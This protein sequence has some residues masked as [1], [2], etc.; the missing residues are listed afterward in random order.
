VIEINGRLAENS[1]ETQA[2]GNGYTTRNE[3]QSADSLPRNRIGKTGLRRLAPFVLA[4]CAVLAVFAIVFYALFGHG[5]VR[6]IYDGKLSGV[7][8]WVM[9][10]RSTTPLEDYYAVA[11]ALLANLLLGL[12]ILVPAAVICLSK[13]LGVLLAAF[14]V[15]VSSFLLFCVFEAIPSLV[16]PLRLDA[17][18]TYYAYKQYYIPDDQLGWR[19]KPLARL[20]RSDFNESDNS[21]TAGTGEPPARL[22]WTNDENGFRNGSLQATYDVVV[23]GDSFMAFGQSEHDTFPKRLQKYLG[24]TVLNLGIGGYGPFQ[25]LEVL[26]QYG[27]PKQP[28]YAL[29]AFYSGNDL[30][31]IVAY[32]KW[33]EG[34]RQ[35][36]YNSG[37]LSVLEGYKV[38]L[39]DVVAKAG[40]S[41][42]H[43][44]DWLLERTGA[45]SGYS[46][47][48]G[49]VAVLDLGGNRHFAMSFVDYLDT[50]P[51]ET[52][53]RSEEW[54][55]LRTILSEFKAVCRRN[56]I[57]PVVLYIP[58]ATE[59]YAK[60]ST[61]ESG[62]GWRHLRLKQ[63]A[64]AG[65]LQT[66]F[67]RLAGE[68]KLDL[69]D[70]TP[71]FQEAAE[72]GQ[73][74]YYS[75]DSHWNA[76]GRELAARFVAEQLKTEGQIHPVGGPKIRPDAAAPD[77]GVSAAAP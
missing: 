72:R 61:N 26:K 35:P 12:I 15:L 59:V 24:S 31:D 22:E 51:P 32:V 70:I 7:A 46:Y 41:I 21:G 29:F 17:L 23:T 74:V 60:Y 19:G 77:S 67:A 56:G 44:I 20:G 68:L 36:M 27:V 2:G 37:E 28:R 16:A 63:I 66:A 45:T 57:K 38:V 42:A 5:I 6:A 10:G 40:R 25:Y 11:D 49:G 13:P 62:T 34:L 54:A 8:E 53:S 30:N 69:I 50:S 43:G 58:S 4:A 71:V 33:K 9:E 14:S 39:A 64:A 65:N 73:V 3:S 47:T 1:V 55:H 75:S 48:E 76:D 52:I 18:S